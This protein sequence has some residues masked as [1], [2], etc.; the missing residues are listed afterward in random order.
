VPEHNGLRRP[1]AAFSGG[2]EQIARIGIGHVKLAVGIKVPG[3]QL[4]V[5]IA[6]DKDEIRVN[7]MFQRAIP[8]VEIRRDYNLAGPVFDHKSVR[9]IPRIVGHFERLKAEIA[10]LEAAVGEWFQLELTPTASVE[11]LVPELPQAPFVDS[12]FDAEAL[13]NSQRIIAYVVR[14]HVRNNCRIDVKLIAQVLRKYL[15]G[16]FH[17]TETAINQYPG[18]VGPDTQAV[19]AAA[20]PQ[21]HEV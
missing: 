10:Y 8:I 3:E 20:T 7:E 2:A 17:G 9:R 6:F 1:L 19:A 13:K 16:P 15:A 14:V 12:H 5:M 21:A 18:A 4:Q 11:M